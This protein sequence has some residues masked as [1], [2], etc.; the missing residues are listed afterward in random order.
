MLCVEIGMNE[1]ASVELSGGVAGALGTLRHAMADP[2]ST[3]G[4]KLELIERRLATM[5]AAGPLAEKVRGAKGDLAVAGRLVDLL[6]RLGSITGEMPADVSIRDVC[7][8]AGLPLGED[9]ARGTRLLLRRQASIDA[10][11]A[12]AEVLRS[13]VPSGTQPRVFAEVTPGR[14]SLRIESPGGNGPAEPERL[15]HLPRGDE[16]AEGLFLARAGVESDGGC[17]EL[18]EREGRL[19]ALL[20]WPRTAPQNDAGTPP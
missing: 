3:A 11:R 16:R 8:V 19:V 5:A 15:F 14:V 13:V 17:L 1:K 20:S 9:E 7:R 6:P 2:L 10:L 18:T 4:L 12:V